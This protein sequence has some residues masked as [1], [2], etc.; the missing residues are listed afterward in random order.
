[1]LESLWKLCLTCSD[2]VCCNSRSEEH[3]TQTFACEIDALA[4]SGL[5]IEPESS[6]TNK[7]KLLYNNG[8]CH[9]YSPDVGC[10]VHEQWRPAICRAYPFMPIRKRFVVN[11]NCKPM[12]AKVEGMSLVDRQSLT[13]EL[14]EFYREKFNVS[15]WVGL[16]ELALD[17]PE[18]EY[19]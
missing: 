19:I 11:V 9:Q 16:Q 14:R 18:K 7:F 10:R 13:D 4:D 17:Y 6:R 2:P 5:D 8:T 15:E 12:A 3:Q 1:M